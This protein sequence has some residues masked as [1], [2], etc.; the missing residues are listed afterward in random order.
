MRRALF[1]GVLLLLTLGVVQADSGG[2]AQTVVAGNLNDGPYSDANVI[3]SVPVNTNL[4]II[5]RQGGWYNVRLASGQSGWVPMTNL[6]LNGGGAAGT[7]APAKSSSSGFFSLFESGRSGAS[8]TTATTG[9]RGLNTGDIANAKPDPAAVT[10]LAQWTAKPADAKEFANQLPA[11]AV[12]V[13]SL[14]KVKP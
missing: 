9:V 3:G 2:T 14:P 12:Q 11:K 10:E 6:R 13:D 5:S 4:T 7:T 8:G 1:M